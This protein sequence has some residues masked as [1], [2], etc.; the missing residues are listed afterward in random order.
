MFPLAARAVFEAAGRLGEATVRRIYGDF[1]KGRLA[2]WDS[3]IARYSIVPCHQPSHVRGKNAADIALAVDAMDFLMHRERLDGFCLVSSDSDFT[4]LAQRLRKGGL[5]V[6]GFGEGKTPGA[7]RAACH[8]FETLGKARRDAREPGRQFFQEAGEMGEEV[9][10]EAAAGEHAAEK[11]GDVRKTRGIRFSESEWEEV[12][13]A[14]AAH[15][16]PAAE[17]VRE[18]ILALA[19]AAERVEA[20][21]V[22]GS[23]APMIERM[24]RYTWFLASEKR[25]AMVREGRQ[26]ELDALVA[27]ARSFQKSLCRGA[28]D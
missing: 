14:A 28:E 27:E 4:R 18:R 13:R 9:R 3:A 15:E 26:D 17:F 8:R 23:M 22:A 5:V 1:C 21:P 25:G 20:G 19:R 16:M 6:Y 12:K 10:D 7:F 24:F 11:S 2:S